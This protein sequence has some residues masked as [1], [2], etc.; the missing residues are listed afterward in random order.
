MADDGGDWDDDGPRE[1]LEFIPH[2]GDYSK[3]D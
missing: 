2:A 1:P 3:F